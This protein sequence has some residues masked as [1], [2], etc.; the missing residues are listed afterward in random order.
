MACYDGSDYLNAERKRA[1]AIQDANTIKQVEA[2]VLAALNAHDLIQNYS[3]QH[4]IADRAMDIAESQQTHLRTT[5]WPRE[6]DFLNEF[7]V[8]EDI[9]TVEVLGRR[10][11]GRLVSTISGVFAAKMRQ[12]DCAASRYCTSKRSKDIQDLLLLRSQAIANARI[13]GRIMG[14]Y[15]VQARRDLNDTRRRQA[16]GL[17]KGLMEAAAKLYGQASSNLAV[18]GQQLSGQVS[19]ALEGVGLFNERANIAERRIDSLNTAQEMGIFDDPQNSGAPYNSFSFENVSNNLPDNLSNPP[20][21]TFGFD[22]DMGFDQTIADADRQM[23]FGDLTQGMANQPWSP[24]QATTKERRN[25]GRVG[26]RDLARDGSKT[27]HTTGYEGY[28]IDITVKMSDFP[29]EW[30]DS[31]KEGDT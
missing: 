6:I 29:L 8:P 15:D 4:A 18:I 9:E 28:P 10:H 7:G 2:V 17:G 26:N 5:F 11:A 13:L 12:L 25:D 19:R 30:V 31:K 23:E 1:S 21:N 16:V 14:F 22:L 24:W 3:D 20:T 27:Y